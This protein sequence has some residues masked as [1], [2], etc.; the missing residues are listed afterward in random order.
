MCLWSYG[1]AARLDVDSRQELDP[2]TSMVSSA[3]I[4]YGFEVMGHPIG[5]IVSGGARAHP[6]R[7]AATLDESDLSFEMLDRNADCLGHALRRIG[8]GHE[9]VV[10]W[11]SGSVLE[12]LAGMVACARVG[13]VFTALSPALG[14]IGAQSVLEYL[15]PRLLV[16][17]DSTI[18]SALTIGHTELASIGTSNPGHVG[19]LG[20]MSDS[21]A[22]SALCTPELSDRDPH[23]LYLTSGSTGEPKGVLVSHRA[24]WLRSRAG[25]GSYRADVRG[26]VCSFPLYHSGGWH[27]VLVA[28]LNGT[29]VHLVERADGPELV[30]VVER[31]R[32]NAIYCIPA[33]WERVLAEAGD[34]G[35]IRYA[36][37]GTSAVAGDLLERIAQRLPRASTTV[38][39]GATE[40]GRMTALSEAKATARPGCV[41]RAVEPGRIELAADGE[42]VFSGPTMMEGYLR[43]PEETATAVENGWYHTGD[44]GERDEDGLLYI[45]GRKREV[46]RSG[47]ETIL[48]AE[49]ESALRGLPGIRELAI[50]G[51]PDAWWGELVCVAV[52]LAH[53]GAAP[54]VEE[55][56]ARLGSV[57]AH[58]H[59]RIVA[60][61]AEIPR[62]SATGQ[63]RRGP[64]RDAV[65]AQLRDDV[66]ATRGSECRV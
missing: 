52:V 35:S 37:T 1:T 23:I 65:L 59:P 12:N 63:V 58:K 62:T 48:P 41:G 40:A 30:S 17:D 8:V 22:A 47:G 6:H 20:A 61:V 28:W 38:L 64:L 43:L 55:P 31:R 5:D 10:A 60:T 39:Y 56:R 33:V 54:T 11:W 19:N 15:D 26:V 14:A 9:E 29:T 42:F 45:T 51:L 49:L 13:A 53:G 18:E 25:G 46:I 36:D 27:Y 32:P 44:L 34:L 2:R 7:L 3:N 4:N 66:L 21:G 57:A 24:S 50:V 16:C